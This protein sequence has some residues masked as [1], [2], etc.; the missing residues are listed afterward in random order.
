[1]KKFEF[2]LN[3][4]HKVREIRKELESNALSIAQSELSVAAKRLDDIEKLHSEATEDLSSRIRGGRIGAADMESRS[5]YIV[6]LRQRAGQ[7]RKEFETK[8]AE[9][10]HQVDRVT[11]AVRDVKVTEKLRETK[12][13]R[14]AIDV[15]RK[16]QSDIDEL[17]TTAYS[18]R[19]SNAK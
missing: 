6:S 15:A 12:E 19:M 1:M 5:A 2:K 9:V 16:E 17:V 8:Q 4:V 13:Q 11:V 14:Y 7:A 3:T 18:R 10:E